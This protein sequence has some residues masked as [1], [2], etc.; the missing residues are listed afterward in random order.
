LTTIYK[1]KI[2]ITRMVKMKSEVNKKVV[3]NFFVGL[4]LIGISGLLLLRSVGFAFADH[5]PFDGVVQTGNINICHSNGNGGYVSNSPSIDSDGGNPH[6]HNNQGAHVNDIIPPYHYLDQDDD[7]QSYPGRNW[8]E[9]N[10]AIW[11]N[12]CVAPTPSPSPTA[13]ATASST[14]TATPTGTPTSTPSQ[15]PSS[16]PTTTPEVD[17][18]PTPTP[19]ESPT[20]T[21]TENPTATPTSSSAT[22]PPTSDGGGG[23]QVLGTSTSGQVLGAS[24]LGAA[25]N[26]NEKLS[27]LILLFGIFILGVGFMI[28]GYFE[29]RKRETVLAS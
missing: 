18:T 21:P 1:I 24:T 26:T 4:S 7:V 20:A 28:N 2:L 14:P 12:G 22:T 13:T 8:N 15:G 23:G 3:A 17:S 25:G 16:T 9:T 6:G 29:L 11:E 10:E 27:Q 5:D 19:T